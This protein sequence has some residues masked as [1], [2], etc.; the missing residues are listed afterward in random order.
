MA[1]LA[2]SGGISSNGN[3]AED[4]D[5]RNMSLSSVS[6]DYDM[7]TPGVDV[8]SR[9]ETTTILPPGEQVSA[10][11][12]DYGILGMNSSSINSEEILRWFI[13]PQITQVLTTLV[14]KNSNQCKLYKQNAIH[15]LKN[16]TQIID[17]TY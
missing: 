17:I 7:Q 10:G 1:Y 15:T 12:A 14:C 16:L 5:K 11:L 13:L 6:R 2:S 3:A 8:V 9:E 4:L